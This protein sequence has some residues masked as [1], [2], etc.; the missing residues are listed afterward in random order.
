[1]DRKERNSQY[2][3]IYKRSF[4]QHCYFWHID[5]KIIIIFFCKYCMSLYNNIDKNTLRVELL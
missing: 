1:M 5:F 3:H 2:S 4:T